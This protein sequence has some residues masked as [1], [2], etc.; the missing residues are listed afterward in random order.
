MLRAGSLCVPTV[1]LS[2]TA[3][4]TATAVSTI[5]P[6]T[7][8]VAVAPGGLAVVGLVAVT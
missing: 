2:P 6:L 7:P 5:S 8:V 3:I 4:W 1:A